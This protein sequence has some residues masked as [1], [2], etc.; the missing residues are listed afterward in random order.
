METTEAAPV[1][2]LSVAMR[3]LLVAASVL[4]FL[5]GF[6]L[7]ILTEQ[8]EHYFAWTIQPPLTAAFL[9]A[10]Y[11]SSFLLEILASRERI[12]ARARIAVPAVLAFTTLTLVAT[13][14]HFDRFHFGSTEIFARVAAWFWLMIYLVV[15]PI[16]LVLW[17]RQQRLL[18][19]NPHRSAS[20]PASMRVILVVQS[21]FMLAIG[22]ALFIMPTIAQL[23]WPWKLTPLTSMAVGAW[24]IGVGVFAGH[25]AWE[26]DFSRIK[27][28]LVS[29]LAFGLLQ[30]VGLGRFPSSLQWSQLVAWVY[31]FFMV[32]VLA[33][34]LYGLASSKSH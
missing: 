29:Y 31:L 2:E 3:R 21:A 16:M 15:P 34:S 27:A 28:G 23:L 30:L 17:I 9:G 19:R 22:V 32:T 10:G 20:L 5:A 4:V 24:L 25:A 14:V 11:W 8:T 33:V 1:R 26:N 7:F 18:G 6:Q 13:L 12:W